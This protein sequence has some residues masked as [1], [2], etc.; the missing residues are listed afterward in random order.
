MTLR[1]EWKDKTQTRRT[2]LQITNLILKKGSYSEYKKS[3]QNSVKRKQAAQYKVQK[4]K[5]KTE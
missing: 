4:E 3:P 5:K 2:H 1:R